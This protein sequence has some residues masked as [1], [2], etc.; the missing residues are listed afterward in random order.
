MP[1]NACDGALNYSHM[2]CGW[3]NCRKPRHSTVFWT[4]CLPLGM[5]EIRDR[6][7]GQNFGKFG[8]LK[9]G[10]NPVIILLLSLLQQVWPSYWNNLLSSQNSTSTSPRDYYYFSMALRHL[11]N[12][13]ASYSLS[14]F[15]CNQVR[16]NIIFFPHPRLL[17]LRSVVCYPTPTSHGN[18][19]L[20]FNYF[21][22][23]W[24]FN[25]LLRSCFWRQVLHLL[26]K[27]LEYVH[28]ENMDFLARKVLQS[29]ASTLSNSM[30]GGVNSSLLCYWIFT[31]TFAL[32]S[33]QVVFIQEWNI[34]PN[35]IFSCSCSIAFSPIVDFPWLVSHFR[36]HPPWN[37]S[38]QAPQF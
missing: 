34:F 37:L 5:G 23:A 29:L 13:V 30:C 38:R 10:Q 11:H 19:S 17:M 6:C 3:S 15:L 2:T 28:F 12:I 20:V 8:W 33:L 9:M 25:F 26:L 21:S 16:I 24:T 14:T 1:C 27:R 22:E 7:R 4:S 32:I 36:V 31:I 35:T 18:F